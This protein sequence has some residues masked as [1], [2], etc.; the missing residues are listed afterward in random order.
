VAEVI[1]FIWSEDRKNLADLSSISA[2]TLAIE[3]R[4]SYAAD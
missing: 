2:K 1:I 3:M 4:V